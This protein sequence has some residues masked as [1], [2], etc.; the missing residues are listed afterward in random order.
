MRQE[1]VGR[2]SHSLSL[3]SLG[4]VGGLRSFLAFADFEF[5]CVAFLQA[6]VAFGGDGAVVDEDVRSIRAPDEAVT[7]GVIEPLDGSFQTFHVIPRF[8]HVPDGGPGGM[9]PH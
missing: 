1:T 2:S 6:L 9:H 4:D 7:L 3:R 5:D 8:L